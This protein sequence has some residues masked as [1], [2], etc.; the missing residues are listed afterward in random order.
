MFNGRD[1]CIVTN[2][3]ITRIILWSV[4]PSCCI[5]SDTALGSVTQAVDGPGES[6][7][8]DRSQEMFV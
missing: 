7:E 5:T 3:A 4:N 2:R 8:K 1:D 6:V